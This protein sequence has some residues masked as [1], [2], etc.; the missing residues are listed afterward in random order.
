MDS[1]ALATIPDIIKAASTSVLGILALLI[2]ILGTLAFVFFRHRKEYQLHVFLCF[3]IGIVGF[4]AVLIWLQRQDATEALA[5]ASRVRDLRLHLL[6]SGAGSANPMRAVVQ[7]FRQGRSDAKE[8]ALTNGVQTI[9][10]A[11]GVLLQFDEL[12]MGD[13]V[14]VIVSDQGKQWRSD[15]MRVLEAQL[16]MNPDSIRP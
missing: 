4:G 14:Y 6:F 16:A 9:R 3:F 2:V 8:I 12:Q 7:A 15:D 10:G 5:Q 11:G 1:K 13:R